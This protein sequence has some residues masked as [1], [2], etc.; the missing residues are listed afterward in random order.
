MIDY[1]IYS[2]YYHLGKYISKSSPYLFLLAGE[3]SF[4]ES[5]KTLANS[6][7]AL[8]AWLYMFRVLEVFYFYFYSVPF[9]F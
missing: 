2:Y 9:S 4:N 7:S 8:L 3:T 1:Y 5:N 6:N